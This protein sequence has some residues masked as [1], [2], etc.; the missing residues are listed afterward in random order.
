MAGVV[1]IYPVVVK[2]NGER[3]HGY[4]R[5]DPGVAQLR[6]VEDADPVNDLTI[7]DLAR[8]VGLSVRNLRSHQARGLLPPP[9]VRG[10]VGYYGPEHVERVRL[11]QE[12]QGEGLKLDGI[13][14]LLEESGAAGAGLLRVKHAADAFEEGEGSEVVS[15]AELGERFG[16]GA[17]ALKLVDRAVKLGVL[18]PLG[19]DLYEV[20]SPTLLGAAESVVKRGISLA[21][22][23]DLVEELQRHSRSVSEK[24]VKQFLADVWKPFSDAGMP[25]AQWSEVADSMDELRPL[26]ALALT[27]VFRRTLSDEV[28]STFAEITRR[29]SEGKR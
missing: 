20:P 7:D 25:E 14:R 27:T 22:A 24:F 18:V 1:D 15:V 6:A 2:R 10:R 17:D 23:L 13:K 11:I 21:H 28:E 9:E 16:V 5:Y 4:R 26:A 12:L 19:G 29:L 3:R 8:E